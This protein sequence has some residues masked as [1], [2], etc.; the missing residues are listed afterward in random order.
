VK[1]DIKIAFIGKV[2]PYEKEFYTMPGYG[3]AGTLAQLGFLEALHNTPMGLDRAWGFRPIA[4][5]PRVKLQF[6]GSRKCILPCGVTLRLLPLVN[7]FIIKEIS[8]FVCIAC[9]M[10][11]WSLSRIGKKRVLVIYNLS[12]PTGIVWARFWTWLTHTKLVPIVYDMAQI[13]SFRKSLLI[14]LTEPD[15]LDRI[16][17]KWLHLCDGLIPITSAIPQDFAPNV[18]YIVIDGGVGDTVVN[19]VSKECSSSSVPRKKEDEKEF[20]LFY[21]GSLEAWNSIGL[22]LSY[23]Q[24][25]KDPE[26]RLWIAGAGREKECVLRHA[27]M[28]SRIKYLGVLNQCE[29]YKYYDRADVLLNMRDITDPGLKYHYPSKTFEM[30]AMGKPMIVTDL[31][32]TKKDYGKY[33]MVVETAT[34]EEM[35]RGVSYFR[36]MT[37]EERNEF[38][39]R[40]KE[41]VLSKRK[42]S[43]RGKE[44]GLFLKSIFE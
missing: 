26:L 34:I 19:A 40:V 15:W 10:L 3:V 14:R 17:E 6:E 7:H 22:Y 23:M 41:F 29:L 28:D 16:H 4:H 25:N 24:K 8:W 27:K 44:I 5:W 42:W 35:D 13:K 36:K 12:Q 33:C 1:S 9:C 30:M 43:S 39:E 18:P 20:V 11:W 2:A 38:G 37:N 32:H 21:C 31:S